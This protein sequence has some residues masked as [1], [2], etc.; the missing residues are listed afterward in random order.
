MLQSQNVA[1]PVVLLLNDGSM[2]FLQRYAE[3]SITMS[4]HRDSPLDSVRES[5]GS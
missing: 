3:N 1:T 5:G 2:R 4:L